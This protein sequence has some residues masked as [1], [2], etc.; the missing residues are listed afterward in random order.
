MA[1]PATLMLITGGLKAGGKVLKGFGKYQK[2]KYEKKFNE[3]Q[4]ERAN[5][6]GVAQG[7]VQTRAGRKGVGSAIARA[8]AGGINF[9]G[10]ALDVTAQIALEAEQRAGT[11]RWEGLSRAVDL[12]NA[13]RAAKSKGIKAFATGIGEGLVSVLDTV[14]DVQALNAPKGP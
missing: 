11:A 4:A 1:N 5:D 8:G 12:R 10:S 7:E 9:S 14:Q 3:K 2:G 13:G 6:I